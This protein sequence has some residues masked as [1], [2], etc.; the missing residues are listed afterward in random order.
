MLSCRR[1]LQLN[2]T[3]PHVEEAQKM[4][5][6]VTVWLGVVVLLSSTAVS[7]RAPEP[8]AHRLTAYPDRPPAPEEVV[9]RGKAQYSVSCSFCHGSDAGG[10]VGPNLLR[11]QVVLDDKSGDLILPIVHGARSDRG[12]PQIDLNDAQ[13]SDIAVFLHSLHVTSHVANENID[14]V[15][16]DP[17]AG[18]AFFTTA[19][20]AKSPGDDTKACRPQGTRRVPCALP[21]T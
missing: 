4:R 14:I 2:L 5:R 20:N 8:P 15:V 1:L 19:E 16:G 12:M 7:I 9:D 17:K 18:E 21:R 11:S 3:G 6:F 10:G 13:V